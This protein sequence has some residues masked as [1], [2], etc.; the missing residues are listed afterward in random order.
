MRPGEL[1]LKPL[2]LPPAWVAPD[3]EFYRYADL[4][5]EMRV[6]RMKRRA[7]G[8]AAEEVDA[9]FDFPDLAMGRHKVGQNSETGLVALDA[10]LTPAN[11]R[12]GTQHA[13]TCELPDGTLLTLV[14]AMMLP[15]SGDAAP[16]MATCLVASTDGGRTWKYRSAIMGSNPEQGW[17]GTEEASI[18]RRPNGRLLCVVRNEMR[19]TGSPTLWITRSSDEGHTW[20]PPERLNAYTALP[21]L[22]T[23][24]NG[25][26]ACV[27][28]RPG[29]SLRFSSDPDCRVWSNPHM[30]HPINGLLFTGWQDST[31][32]YT[33]LVPLGADRFL[34][35]YS[36]FYHRDEDWTLHKAI[37]AREV[38]VT[39]K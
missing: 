38:R 9:P 19:E 3:A 6:I 21:G 2:R 28:G 20:E 1:G 31:C 39:V 10:P 7:P 25:V 34:V 13:E 14:G 24:D 16:Y 26:V 37:K 11:V 17:E 36:D 15:K 29:I 33:S 12:W 27:H 22:I 5:A 30:L 35:V 4:P 8:G 18:V 23:L 32:G